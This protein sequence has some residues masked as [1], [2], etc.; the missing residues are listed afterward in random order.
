MKDKRLGKK[1]NN[2]DPKCPE[3]DMGYMSICDVLFKK[4]ECAICGCQYENSEVD[5]K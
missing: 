4:Y 5:K 2:S 3:C 1:I